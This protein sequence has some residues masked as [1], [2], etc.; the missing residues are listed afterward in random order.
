MDVPL[1]VHYM[2]FAVRQFLRPGLPILFLFPVIA[3]IPA[4]QD[5]TSFPVEILDDPNT[6]FAFRQGHGVKAAFPYRHTV[7]AEYVGGFFLGHRKAVS[8]F[9]CDNALGPLLY[10][11]ATVV[12][13]HLIACQ[14]FVVHKG[15]KIQAAV[16]FGHFRHIKAVCFR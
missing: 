15:T 7:T 9:R 12:F 2:D 8:L 13:P 10:R 3:I 5:G 11:T 16:A 1:A 4:E 14:L 6:V